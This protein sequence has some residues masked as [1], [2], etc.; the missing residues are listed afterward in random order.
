MATKITNK[1]TK[2]NQKDVKGSN[3]TSII[4]VIK[5][6][7]NNNTVRAQD[8][9]DQITV[10]KGK[11]HKLYGDAGNDTIT[12][13]KNAATGIKVYGG[14]GND[15]IKI[16]GGSGVYAYG[17]AGNDKFTVSGG[18]GHVLTGGTGSDTYTFSAAI[19]KETRLTIYQTGAASSD[20]DVLQLSKA[21]RNDISFSYNSKKK[22]LTATHKTGGKIY[23]KNWTTHPLTEVQFAN[24]ASVHVIAGNNSTTLK[25]TSGAD[26]ILAGSSNKTVNAGKGADTV[27]ITTGSGYE[28][29]SGTGND[30]VYIDGGSAKRIVNSGGTD[31]IE[32]GKKAGNGIK[33]ESVGTSEGYKL[34][35]NE[36]VEVLG[37]SN[38]DIRLYGGNDKVIVAGGSG[39][40]V[41]T[42]GPTGSGDGSGD[43]VIVVQHGG[44]AKTIVAGEGND[45]IAV[46]KDAGQAT[47]YTGIDKYS[48]TSKGTNTVNLLGG[49]GHNVYLN[50][51][52][53]TV[54]VAAKDVTLNQSKNTIDKITVELTHDGIGTLRINSAENQ[55]GKTDTLI[56]RGAS[57]EDFTFTKVSNMTAN[58]GMDNSQGMGLVMTFN[59]TYYDNQNLQRYYIGDGTEGNVLGQITY[60]WNAT[61]G[62]RYVYNDTGV[63][64]DATIEIFRWIQCWNNGGITFIDQYGNK[65]DIS[66]SKINGDWHIN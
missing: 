56:I 18:N 66:Y 20:K 62:S 12:V 64:I 32:I 2:S 1:I 33:V 6:Y 26:Y 17:N 42:D 10:Y 51:G 11:D 5:V 45:L 61:N 52:D 59:G 16:K 22:I 4:D 13:T 49:S 24:N 27:R 15:T 46:T 7:G 57:Y 39:H 36:T 31:Y 40:T 54:T 19:A 43:D 34:V 21:N 23:V 30:K 25:G 8:G 9:N 38:H 48:V 47:I 3:S 29:N 55:Y 60:N 14:A 28:I 50:G 41:Y 37:G 58:N 44:R 53:N 63:A 65:T 35:A